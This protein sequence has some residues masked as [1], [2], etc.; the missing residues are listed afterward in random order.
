MSRVVVT[1]LSIKKETKF[2]L[3]EETK[4]DVETE[5]EKK[6]PVPLVTHVNNLLHSTF[7]NVEVYINNQQSTFEI[8]CM[9]TN[10]TLPT[11]SRE[12]F[13]KAMYFCIARGKIMKNLLMKL[14]KRL[15]LNLFSHGE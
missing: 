9:R 1:K 7:S 5:E 15:C 2:E 14:W 11:T 13:L 10:L 4:A 12:P 6:I 8:D 3:K